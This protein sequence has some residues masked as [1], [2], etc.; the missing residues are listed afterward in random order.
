VNRN[1]NRT[2][3]TPDARR[4]IL[5]ISVLLFAVEC[6]PMRYENTDLRRR[7][8]DSTTDRMPA[9]E[10][11]K[12]ARGDSTPEQNRQD[13]RAELRRI[14]KTVPPDTLEFYML[15]AHC[16]RQL[17]EHELAADAY[18]N[19]SKKSSDPALKV[20]LQ[21]KAVQS[22]AKAG[23]MAEGTG[24]WCSALTLYETCNRYCQKFGLGQHVPHEKIEHLKALI[25]QD[26]SDN[27][28]RKESKP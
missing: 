16:Y 4:S 25:G 13:W 12:S 14:Q 21:T 23:E 15:T 22:F 18:L 10:I 27:R 19:A 11:E 26:P 6:S 28:C 2:R 3:P 20:E 8:F 9:L 5:A 1:N 24:N 17:G 7:Q